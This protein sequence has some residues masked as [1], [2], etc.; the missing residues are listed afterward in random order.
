MVPTSNL[1]TPPLLTGM[2]SDVPFCSHSL[3]L[4]FGSSRWVPGRAKYCPGEG[5]GGSCLVTGLENTECCRYRTFYFGSGL[6]S[7]KISDPTLVSMS[8]MDMMTE[9]SVVSSLADMI[10]P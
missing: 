8:M 3:F 10:H 7:Q 5:G 9:K 4:Q 1:T 6:T 2:M